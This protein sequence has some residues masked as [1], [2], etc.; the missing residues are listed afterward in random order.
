MESDV[1]FNV[2]KKRRHGGD[3]NFFFECC[4]RLIKPPI[5]NNV[6]VMH[7]F[8]FF[9]FLETGSSL[10]FSAYEQGLALYFSQYKCMR[11]QIKIAELKP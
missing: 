2:K 5:D 11:F 8:F 6:Y 9:F 10:L 4:H 7:V 3:D 1:H